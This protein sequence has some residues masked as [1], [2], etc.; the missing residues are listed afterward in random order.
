MQ[1]L[2]CVYIFIYTYT[3]FFNFRR[4]TLCGTLDYLPPEMIENKLHN[5]RVDHWSLGVLCYEFLV[6]K[7]PFETQTHQDTY[8][9]ICKVKICWPSFLSDGAKDLISSVSFVHNIT[10]EAS[11][12]MV[13]YAVI[14]FRWL[15][16]QKINY[17]KFFANKFS[18]YKERFIPDNKIILVI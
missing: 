1:L 12:N 3:L 2:L 10:C 15:C 13:Y 18:F 8:A 4:A 11:F 16:T 14:F 9:L 7:P 17:H 6:G 5:E